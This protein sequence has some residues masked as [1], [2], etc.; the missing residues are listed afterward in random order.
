M[1]SYSKGFPLMCLFLEFIFSPEVKGKIYIS[2]EH[3]ISIDE[4]HKNDAH[5]F[6]RTIYRFLGIRDFVILRPNA[7]GSSLKYLA[8]YTLV[9]G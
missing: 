6:P 3:W 2:K 9:E 1:Y 5:T 4:P 7:F 8:R